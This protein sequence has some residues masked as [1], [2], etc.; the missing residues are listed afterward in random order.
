M[1]NE[2]FN[3]L[4][5]DVITFAGL[6]ENSHLNGI[7]F[8]CIL[9]PANNTEDV[10]TFL[11][12]E[13]GKAG[14]NPNVFNYGVLHED[15]KYIYVAYCK[16]TGFIPVKA[17]RYEI[18]QEVNYTNI[19]GVNWGKRAIIG[20]YY[21]SYQGINQWQYFLSEKDSWWCPVDEELLELVSEII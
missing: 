6:T 7:S 12:Q 9:F 15:E 13:Q 16:E 18:G 8:N 19:F 2:R 10:N 3:H 1:K 17:A 21:E 5:R 14:C 11:K 20:R 4:T